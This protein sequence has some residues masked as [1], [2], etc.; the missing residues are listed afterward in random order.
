MTGTTWNTKPSTGDY[1][2]SNNW[3]NGVPGS[4]DTAFFG[5]STITSITIGSSEQVGDWVFD[6]WAS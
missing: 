6:P 4:G 2:D 5:S 1:G 3:S